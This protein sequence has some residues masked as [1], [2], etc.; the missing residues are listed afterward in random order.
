MSE[1]TPVILSDDDEPHNEDSFASPCPAFCKRLRTESYNRRTVFVIDDDPTPQK[2]SG[3]GATPLL[4][5]E[6]PLSEMM[7]P[8]VGIFRCNKLDNLKTR[9]PSKTDHKDRGIDDAICLESDSESEHSTLR[10]SMEQNKTSF[11]SIEANDSVSDH[12]Y[13]ESTS[14]LGK[15]S[16]IFSGLAIINDNISDIFAGVVKESIEGDDGLVHMYSDNG[17]NDVVQELDFGEI[18]GKE[19]V[20]DVSKWGNTCQ[21]TEENEKTVDVVTKPK[22][23]RMTM[24]ERTHLKE[25]KRRKKEEEKL[26]KA[27]LKAE[28][29]EMKKL[30]KEK[31]KWE[32]GKFAVQ[33]IV[34]EIDTEVVELGSIGGHLLTRFA[35]KGVTYRIKSN[36]IKRSILWSMTVPEQLSQVPTDR[37]EIP[38]ILFVYDAD[39]FCKF[40]S[41]QS[42]MDHASFVRSRYSSH[43]VCY[44]TNRLRTYINKREQAHYKNPM[45]SWRQPPV[46]EVLSNLTTNFAKVHSRHCIDEAELAEHVVSLTSSLASCQFRTKLTRLSVNANGNVI[47]KDCADKTSFKKS[48]WL[49]ALVAIPKVQPRFAIAIS[50]KYPTMRSLLEVYMDPTKSVHEKEFLLKDLNT[51]GLTGEDRRL[52]EI[53]SKRVYRVLMAQS[54][55]ITTDDIEDGADFFVS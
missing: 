34:A 26:Q 51:E 1:P 10:V 19:Q 28:A 8:Q 47:P 17:L 21:S 3:S 30:D 52:G 6:T 36:P 2:K 33:S 45:D 11:S 40:V 25:E 46:E 32:K 5:P 37:I 15:L 53:C 43:T 13:I 38:Y 16:K 22:G 54:G 9:V 20:D 41:N 23:K 27:A 4:V 50:K 12:G 39:D 7:P 55:N 44:V 48:F 29:A 42:L 35:E 49:K 18:Y 31:Q 14:F 24:E